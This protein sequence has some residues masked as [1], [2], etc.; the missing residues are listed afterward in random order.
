[1]TSVNICVENQ[2]AQAQSVW[3]SLQEKANTLMAGEPLLSDLLSRY[4]LQRKCLGDALARLL[5]DKLGRETLTS[6]KLHALFTSIYNKDTNLTEAGALDIQGVLKHDPA[7]KDPLNPLL[8]L[9]GF[10]A[11]QSW[12]VAH[13]LWQ[14]GQHGLAL[15]LQSLI[16][17]IFNVDIHP[18]A[19]I[20]HGVTLDHASGIVIGE[21]AIVGNDVL[22]LHGVTLGT[23]GF[24]EGDRHPIVKDGAIIGVGAKVIGRITVG[25]N[26]IVAAG[27][28][29]VDAVPDGTTVAG[30][31][32]RI[33]K[34]A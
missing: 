29:V 14:D 2:G 6:D 5:S 13:Y 17:E 12:R 21:T 34:S 22:M 15:Y 33:V 16:S 25:K 23:K 18:A 27:S 8:F 20:G 1:M 4:V 3:L 10:Q 31:P 11:L 9:K 32:A 24:E 7:T 19:T 30:V 28:V 26:A